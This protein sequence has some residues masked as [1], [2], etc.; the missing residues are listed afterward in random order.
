MSYATDF[1]FG[2]DL[3]KSADYS[4]LVGFERRFVE[5]PA[6]PRDYLRYYACR[7]LHRWEL[8]TSYPDIVDHVCEAMEKCVQHWRKCYRKKADEPDQLPMLAVDHTGVGQAVVDFLRKGRPKARLHPILITAGHKATAE[9]DGWHVP[10]K[11]LVSALQVCLGTDRLVVG[12]VEHKQTLKAELNEFSVKITTAGNEQFAAWRE[13]EHDDLVLGAT[14]GLWLGE[15][16][17]PFAAPSEMPKERRAHTV[18]E[19]RQQMGGKGNWNRRGM[20]GT[21]G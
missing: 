14:C 4:A 17:V 8:G 1:L 20:F 7:F 21:R 11:D 19:R 6:R 15:R 16:G 13:R 2:L 18:E 9:P 10:K 3:G 12:D 5:N